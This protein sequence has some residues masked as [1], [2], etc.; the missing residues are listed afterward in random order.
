MQPIEWALLLALSFMWGGSFFFISVAVKE[1]PPLTLVVL[2]LGFAAVT[3]HLVSLVIGQRAR[4]NLK[5]F[6]ALGVL[7]LVTNVIPFSLI[8]WGQTHIASGL[9]S[10]LNAT[11]PLF[12]LIVAHYLTHDEKMTPARVSGLL[13][14]FTGIVIMIGTD[15]L[16]GLGSNVLGQLAVVCAAVC[17][18]FGGVI[19]RRFQRLGLSPLQFSTG[20]FTAATVLQLPLALIV[21]QPWNIPT[22][23][24]QAWGAVITLGVMSTAI[25]YIIYFRVL[26]T[27]GVVNIMLVTFLV[28]VTAILLGST[29]LDEVLYPKHFAGMALIG[30]GLMLIDG[31]VFVW[32]R[33]RITVAEL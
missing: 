12:T 28:P 26:A 21:D 8:S 9:A 22:P 13:V 17:Y 33:R 10:I 16:K 2:R 23:G 31:R 18:A 20:L 15:A 4:L 3:L 32:M 19:A 7:A 14:G 29:L 1:L 6:A 24:P 5:V 27:A 11:T 25:A 30:L